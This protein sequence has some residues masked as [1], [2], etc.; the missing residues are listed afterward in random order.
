MRSILLPL[1]S[2]LILCFKIRC[3]SREQHAYP[4]KTIQFLE[5]QGTLSGRCST[6]RGQN[7]TSYQTRVLFPLVHAC[8]KDMQ[9]KSKRRRAAHPVKIEFH[10]CDFIGSIQSFKAKTALLLQ[11]STKLDLPGW[12]T[13]L[14]SGPCSLLLP[15]VQ[16]HDTHQVKTKALPQ[17]IPVNSPTIAAK[18]P[19]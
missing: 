4:Y 16:T 10:L 13:G 8:Y 15:D 1:N 17:Y 3:P 2:E 6:A 11:N 14:L 5:M 7:Q 18:P 9:H 12:L 19:N